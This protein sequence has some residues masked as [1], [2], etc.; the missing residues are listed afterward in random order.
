MKIIFCKTGEVKNVSDG[1][2]R[3]YLLPRGLAV[4]ATPTAVERAKKQQQELAVQRGQN[5]AQWQVLVQSLTQLTVEISA[6]ANA[7][8]TLFGAIPESAIIKALQKKGVTVEES[9]LHLEAPIKHIGPQKVP[10]VFP[11]KLTATIN[12]NIVS[13]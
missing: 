3:N 10:V 6:K 4:V 13:S 1:Y 11:D 8:G 5:E 7:D 12:L 9:W 2:A